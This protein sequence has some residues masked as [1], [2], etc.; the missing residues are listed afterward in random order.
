MAT[1]IICDKEFEAT[2]SD[3]K[4][5]SP[6]CRQKANRAG[7]KLRGEGKTIDFK[8]PMPGSYDSPRIEE[9]VIDEPQEGFITILPAIAVGGKEIE[10]PN[11][12]IELLNELTEKAVAFPKAVKKRSIFD[13]IDIKD[14]EKPL[15]KEEQRKKNNEDYIKRNTK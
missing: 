14:G 7:I 9:A 3:A 15:S 1:C 12:T 10:S 4:I 2:R 8:A 6:A 5:C 13:G 11:L